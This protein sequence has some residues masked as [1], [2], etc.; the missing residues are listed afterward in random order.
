MKLYRR[1]LFAAAWLSVFALPIYAD[2]FTLTTEKAKGEVLTMALNTGVHAT[3]T[4]DGD[5]A[6]RKEVYFTGDFLEIPVL[7]EKLQ[8]NSEET[9]TQLY[10]SENKLTSLNVTNLKNLTTLVCSDNLLNSISLTLNVLLKELYCQ[11]NQISTLSLSK[12]DGLLRLNASQNPLKTLGI[13]DAPHLSYINLAQT[14]LTQFS[15]VDFPELKTCILQEGDFSTV[16]L[17][18][19]IENVYAAQ[20]QLETLDLSENS[21]IQQLWISDNQLVS[22]DLEE[23]KRL[24]ELVAESNKLKKINLSRVS[25]TTMTGFYVADN[26]LPFSSFPTPSTKLSVSVSPQRPY[27]LNA[28]VQEGETLKLDSILYKNVWSAQLSPNVVWKYKNNGNLVP[29][30]YYERVSGGVG[31][32]FKEPLGAIYGEVTSSVYPDFVMQIEGIQVGSSTGVHDAMMTENCNIYAG[33]QLLTLE[34]TTP[35][36]VVVQRIDGSLVLSEKVSSGNYTWSLPS[37]V[38]L[39]NKKKIF[40]R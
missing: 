21:K 38:Y 26:E 7:G 39:V 5:E 19:Q 29:E 10:C 16:K 32:V 17:P 31:F 35:M 13:N 33:K 4:W 40:V 11:R 9:I 24:E 15:G 37:G 23:Q 8:V 27:V 34:C 3:L 28:S 22:L 6:T 20:N 30:E 25:R 36:V 14:K 18:S 2:S 12:N 1:K